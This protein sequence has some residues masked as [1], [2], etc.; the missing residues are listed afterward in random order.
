[1][2]RGPAQ[3]LQE[4]SL[5]HRSDSRSIRRRS[6]PAAWLAAPLA[7]LLLLGGCATHDPQDPLEPYNRAMFGFNRKVD[8]VVLKPVATGYRNVTPKLM[9]RGVTNFFSNLDD[10]W[11][12]GNDFLQG[13]VVL[14]FDGIMRVGVNTVFGLFGLLDVATPMG[15]YRH[16]NDFGL[17]LARWGVGS[18]PYFVM[19]LLG[20]SD[21]RD[22]AGT[23]TGIVY[24]PMNSTTNQSGVRNAEVALDFINTRANLLST[25]A[26]LDQIALDP[27]VFTRDAY[28]QRRRSRVRATRDTGV[29]ATG[30]TDD[31]GEGGAGDEADTSPGDGVPAQAASQAGTQAPAN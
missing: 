2:P 18:G 8:K 27:Y 26:L 14:G 30:P 25:T 4:L 24:S 13:H 29:L 17:T 31:S 20:P 12:S 11:S 22:A 21:I 6:A 23:V 28:L 5:I 7:G 9:R 1:M 19:P 15:L 10:V 16:P 3:R